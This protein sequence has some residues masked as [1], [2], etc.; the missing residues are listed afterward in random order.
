M[1]LG[2][3][4]QRLK[5]IWI[6]PLW[7]GGP[8]TDPA[9]YRPLAMSSHITKTLERLIRKQM[10]EYMNN[11]NLL[12]RYQHGSSTGRS[13]LTQLISQHASLIDQLKNGANVELMYLDFSNAF[14]KVSH[15]KLLRRM[16]SFGFK[17]PLLNWVKAFLT[18]R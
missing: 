17:D 9:E 2:Y 18:D 5:D 8:R 14:D 7:K 10:V 13:T 4:P 15:S 12:E 16:A 6:T 3:L 11:H 1:D